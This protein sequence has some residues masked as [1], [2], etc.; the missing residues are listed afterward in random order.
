MTSRKEAPSTENDGPLL[1]QFA[2]RLRQRPFRPHRLLRN[3]HLQTVVASKIRRRFEWGW[4]RS[5]VEYVDLGDGTRVRTVCVFHPEAG[6]TLIAVHGMA[7]SSDSNYMR[8]IS[9]KAFRSGWNAV[10][11]NLYN[12]NDQLKTPRIFH[13]GSSPELGELVLRLIH[14][15]HIQELF[16]AGVSMGGNLILKLLGEWGCHYPRCLR[17]VGVISPLVDLTRSWQI[18]EKPSNT[19]YRVHFVRSLKGLVRRRAAFLSPFVDLPALMRIATVR[20]FDE[21]FTAPLGGFR[22]AF[23]YYRQASAAP[24]MKAIRVPT[25]C[26]HS[27]DDPLLPWQPLTDPEVLSNRKILTSLT[28][29]GGHV[30]FIERERQDID[31]SWAE[32]RTIDF[33]ERSRQFRPPVAVAPIPRKHSS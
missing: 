31:R 25:L 13:A 14:K 8:G 33:F 32:N 20:E 29:K 11:L 5:Q 27:K 9:H 1:E 17:S 18:L 24:R 26:L 30:A 16:L 12:T 21:L 22:N 2:A 4:R 7:G 6:P 19:L 3:G 10:L 23:D 28:E 15:L